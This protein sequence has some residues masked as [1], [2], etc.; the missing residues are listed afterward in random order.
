MAAA[1]TDDLRAARAEVIREHMESENRHDFDATI[2]TFDHPRYELVATGQVFDGEA[3]VRKYFAN[4]R[5]AFPDQRNELISL[6]HADDAV[7]VE[8]DLLGTHAGTFL[9]FAPTGREF[10]CRMAAIFE[11]NGDR[12]TCERVYY[13]SATILK[14]LGLLGARPTGPPNASAIEG[15]TIERPAAVAV[16]AIERGGA[17]S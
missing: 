6:R 17:A 7:I 9:G 13:D 10:R 12:I 5:A 4:S 3:E 14:Q 8:I 16:D 11:F 1:N 2:A 15:P